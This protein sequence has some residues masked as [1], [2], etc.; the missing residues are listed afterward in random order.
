MYLHICIHIFVYRY[1]YMRYSKGTASPSARRG[2]AALLIQLRCLMATDSTYQEYVIYNQSDI[3]IYLNN[4]FN[5]FDQ[6]DRW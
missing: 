4:I 2:P 3:S 1:T 5:I 6:F